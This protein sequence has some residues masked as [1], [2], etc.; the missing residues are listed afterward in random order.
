MTVVLSKWVLSS[1][2]RMPEQPEVYANR[3][4]G[5]LNRVQWDERPLTLTE[6]REILDAVMAQMSREFGLAEKAARG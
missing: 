2:R 1:G 6:R 3:C 5:L 4:L